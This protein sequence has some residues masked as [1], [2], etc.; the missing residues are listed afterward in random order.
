M[1]AALHGYGSVV[2]SGRMEAMGTFGLV[3]L[4]IGCVILGAVVGFL[5]GYVVWRLGFELIGSAIAL[6][7]AGVGGI[8]A[9]VAV[10]NWWSDRPDR[11]RS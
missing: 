3:L 9:F 4:W 6:V 11:A 5:I 1:I 10:L 2:V 7:G 8:L